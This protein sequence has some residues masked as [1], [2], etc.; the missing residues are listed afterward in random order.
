M[1]VILVKVGEIHLKGQNRPFFER[2]LMDNIREA[3]KGSEARISIA[4][5]RI[6]IKNISDAYLDQALDRLTRVFGIHAVSPALQ[7]E[8]DME[9][10]MRT[11]V[12][13]LAEAGI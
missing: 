12:K 11:A 5:S 6:Y 8:K 13:M 7:V 2:R 1:H 10:I 3:L 4:Q 9:Q